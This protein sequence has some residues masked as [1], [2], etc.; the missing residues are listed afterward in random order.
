MASNPDARAHRR[1]RL[2]LHGLLILYLGL[3]LGYAAVWGLAW[4][5]GLFWRADFS[6]FYTGWTMVE[7]GQGRS[8]F[9]FERQ[10]AVQQ[11]VLGG[12][13]FADGLLPFINPPGIVLLL[14]PLARLPL[15]TAFGWW[16]L[17]MLGLLIWL[18]WLI[19]EI[20]AGWK[21]LERWLALV[22]AVAFPP[23]L[24][25]F[26]LGAFSLLMLV[27]FFQLYLAFKRRQAVGTAL[28]FFLGALKPQLM[29][30]SGAM[31]LGARRWK[32]LAL[33][34][35]A[36]A[37]M[38]L[39]SS[40]L[41]G[42]QIWPDYLARLGMVSSLF[43]RYGIDPAGMYNFRGALTTLLGEGTLLG[44]DRGGLINTVST[45]A[46]VASF[47][48]VILIWSR[49]VDPVWPVFELRMALTLAL[50]LFF[51]L[52]LYPQDGLLYLAPA[53]LFYD[54]LRRNGRPRRAL[55]GFLL[56]CPLF[57]LFTE[58][59]LG[60]SLGLRGPVLAAGV[61][62]GWIIKENLAI[63]WRAERPAAG[64]LLAG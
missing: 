24:T 54:F 3:A 36:A 42:W 43:G 25:N 44:V 29:L 37:A 64:D 11:A 47:L 14:T 12:R 61:L 49:P 22:A 51:N 16:S 28:W 39:I 6:A 8:L 26:L 18:L 40:L 33:A 27:C 21:T 17:G 15:A 32:A 31:L 52:H 2:C 55:A 30:L 59:N 19:W 7:A 38:G 62:L 13:S 35:A 50:A 9:D 46:L 60:A 34:A 20:T 57:F 63:G 58:F 41:L 56:L 5:Q 53:I 10:A 23:M 45:L 4:R 1:T 48:V